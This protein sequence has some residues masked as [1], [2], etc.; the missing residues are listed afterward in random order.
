[1]PSGGPV[2]DQA[3]V[4]RRRNQVHAPAMSHPR[5][6]PARRSKRQSGWDGLASAAQRC[7]SSPCQMAS[8]R[9]NRV[10]LDASNTALGCA[11][12][13]RY[14][15]MPPASGHQRQSNIPARPS[16]AL[17]AVTTCLPWRVYRA[18]KKDTAIGPRRQRHRNLADAQI[19]IHCGLPLAHCHRVQEL[20][21]VE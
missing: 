12:T 7:R 18:D 9:P 13:R 3:A 1:L 15:S 14:R 21:P 17:G 5:H 20:N 19:G 6:S 10:A 16:S 4:C 2:S 11:G 8:A